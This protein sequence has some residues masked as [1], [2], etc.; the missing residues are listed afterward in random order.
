[1]RLG[2]RL[3]ATLEPHDVFDSIVSTLHHAFAP[4]A[5]LDLERDGAFEVVATSG[6]P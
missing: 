5:A 3:Q 6:T 4:F 2:E 1:M